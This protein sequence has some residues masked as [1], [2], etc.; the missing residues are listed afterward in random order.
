LGDA[1]SPITATWSLTAADVPARLAGGLY[2]NMHSSAFPDGEIRGQI[3][4]G[5]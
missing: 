5:S 4:Q 3:D 2:V 1:A